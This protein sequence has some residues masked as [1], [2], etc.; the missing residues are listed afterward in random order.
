MG[1]PINCVAA[2]VTGRHT[3]KDLR[4]PSAIPCYS[5]HRGSKFNSR[6][7]RDLDDASTSSRWETC[8]LQAPYG[9]PSRGFHSGGPKHS[10]GLRLKKLPQWHTLNYD[11]DSRHAS[12]HRHTVS[13]LRPWD[14]VSWEH[15]ALDLRQHRRR[16]HEPN[17]S[18]TDRRDLAREAAWNS[19]HAVSVSKD[20]V[21]MPRSGRAYFRD[22]LEL[23]RDGTI[24]GTRP[25]SVWRE[26]RKPRSGSVEDLAAV[27]SL[28]LF[29]RD[30]V[31]TPGSLDRPA[32]GH[33]V[34]GAAVNRR[35]D[36]FSR[37]REAA[38]P[39]TAPVDLGAAA[40]WFD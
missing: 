19:K 29:G 18:V 28:A 22:P 3:D 38:R 4:V 21:R 13:A 15:A 14:R 8:S 5:H 11:T 31:A 30:V 6:S 35:L 2:G 37:S 34:L 33:S 7:N 39:S 26:M 36:E 16:P 10:E 25:S 27:G 20:N 17:R 24:M 23:A 12:T 1:R 32:T 9:F 40:S